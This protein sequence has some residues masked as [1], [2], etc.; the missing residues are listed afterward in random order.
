[1]LLPVLRQ[2]E[3]KALVL[4]SGKAIPAV[5]VASSAAAILQGQRN[6]HLTSVAG[7]LRR[8]GLSQAAMLAALKAENMAKCNPPLDEGEVEKIAV[9]VARYAVSPSAKGEDP[10]EYAMRVL[11]DDSFD[12]GKHLMFCQDGQFW[13]FDGRKWVPAHRKSIEGRILRT[14]RQLPH[15]PASVPRH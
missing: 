7:G 2:I 10:A 6:N 4:G 5:P 3:Q 12:G 1:M 9:S 14:I 8:S 13:R 15:E 11:L